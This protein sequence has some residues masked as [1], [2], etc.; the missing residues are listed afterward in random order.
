VRLILASVA[1][2]LNIGRLI[3]KLIKEIN[4]ELPK[5][6]KKNNCSKS[7]S[8]KNEQFSKIENFI[9]RNFKENYSKCCVKKVTQNERCYY[10]EIDDNFLNNKIGI[11]FTAKK[12]LS[13]DTSD[14]CVNAYRNL[15]KK[16]KIQKEKIECLIVVTQ[17][18]DACGLPHTSAIVHGKLALENDC[19]AFDISLGCS[20][21]VYALSIIKSF[22]ESHNMSNGLLFTCDP[23]S[24]ILNEEDKNTSLLFGDAATVTLIS[25]YPKLIPKSFIFGTKGIEGNAL[26]CMNHVLTMDGR[27]V[28]NFSATEVPIQINKLLLKNS[29]TVDEIDVFILHQGSK[30]ILDTL[31]KRLGI[32]DSKVPTNIKKIGT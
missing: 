7:V 15:E 27:A 1:K 20:G 24:K 31:K 14:M 13:D 16:I 32:E 19:A 22:M 28:F 26:V 17:N 12:N 30:Y 29:L 18:P 25:T 2:P 6:S 21:Y 5:K 4:V 8:E 9:K 23:Y 3:F 11:H 10:V